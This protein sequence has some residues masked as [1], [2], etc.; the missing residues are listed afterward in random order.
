[1]SFVLRKFD[2]A[3]NAQDSKQQEHNVWFYLRLE[4]IL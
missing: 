1:M 2:D 3:A 4:L